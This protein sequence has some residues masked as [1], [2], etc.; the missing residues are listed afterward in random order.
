MASELPTVAV[1][2]PSWC[3]GR[4][5]GGQHVDAAVLQRHRLGVLVPVDGVL[6]GR[7]DHEAVGLVVHVGGDEG[8]QVEGGIRIEGELVVDELVGRAGVHRLLGQHVAGTE[9][10]MPR[11]A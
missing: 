3:S 1:P 11:E 7:L 2:T 10:V 8:G 4:R 9:W 6:V 5:R